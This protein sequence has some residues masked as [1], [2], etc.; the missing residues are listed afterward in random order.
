MNLKIIYK[1]IKLINIS[2]DKINIQQ[3]S[4]ELN[5]FEKLKKKKFI[6]EIVEINKIKH[7]FNEIKYI[8]QFNQN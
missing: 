4:N 1:I 5:I 8:F 2:L 3:F 6:I 7:I